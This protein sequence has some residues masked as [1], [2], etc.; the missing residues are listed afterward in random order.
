M[1]VFRMRKPVEV[2]GDVT[3]HG[4]LIN[5]EL[6]DIVADILARLEALEAAR[7]EED[8]GSE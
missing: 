8:A 4:R 3:V 6:S 2:D 5:E 7:Q 1:G